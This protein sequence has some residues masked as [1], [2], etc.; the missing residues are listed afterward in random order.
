MGTTD[1]DENV[2]VEGTC[3]DKFEGET[4]IAKCA[5]GFFATNLETTYTCGTDGEF[6]GSLD[7]VGK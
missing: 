6:S 5:E 2:V 7:C 4:C 1:F 3:D